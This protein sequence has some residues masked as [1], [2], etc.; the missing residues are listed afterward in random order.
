VTDLHPAAMSEFDFAPGLRIERRI[1]KAEAEAVTDRWEFGQW[2][3]SHVPEGRK[4]LPD[5]FLDGLAKATGKSR[6]ELQY[7]RQFAER[8]PSRE[9]LANVLDNHPSW[10]DIINDALASD[11]RRETSESREQ[12]TR[13]E[14]KMLADYR[15][16]K[17]VAKEHGTKL[18]AEHI[19]QAEFRLVNGE[20]A[21]EAFANG[22]TDKA[23]ALLGFPMGRKTTVARKAS[24]SPAI[25]KDLP[26]AIAAAERHRADVKVGRAEAGF[27]LYEESATVAGWRKELA[28]KR[29]REAK[30]IAAL[31]GVRDGLS[32]E[33]RAAADLVIADLQRRAGEI[34]E[35]D[36]GT[37]LEPADVTP[38]A[39]PRPDLAPM[40][41]KVCERPATHTLQMTLGGALEAVECDGG[42]HCE[43]HAQ[44][45]I[46]EQQA[47]AA[48]TPNDAGT[49]P[50]FPPSSRLQRRPRRLRRTCRP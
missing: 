42:T 9:A 47:G 10:H 29:S 34:N 1:G 33:A 4:K 31:K 16:A 5:G 38:A 43:A 39:D 26:A 44:A 21:K 8:F 50:R 20:A 35:P 45:G 48:P 11:D 36:A 17:A 23:A 13:D 6:S 2:M 12:L 14:A 24:P 40:G 41:C 49:S 22:E 18:P 27:P 25:P 3:L 46:A 15:D 30:A 19:R 28:K 37:F 7:R 32:D